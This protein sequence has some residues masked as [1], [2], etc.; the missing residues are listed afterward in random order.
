MVNV[1]K[2]GT[3][4]CLLQEQSKKGLHCLPFNQVFCGINALKNIRQKNYG[5]KCLKY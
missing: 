3:A 5:T 1:L 2:F 4:T